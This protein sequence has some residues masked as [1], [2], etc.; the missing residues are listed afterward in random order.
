MA[1]DTSRDDVEMRSQA[2]IAASDGDARA[3]VQALLVARPRGLIARVEGQT[4]YA[5]TPHP[6]FSGAPW[7]I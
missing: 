2:V 1:A 3:A 4:A 7:A 5:S 6:D